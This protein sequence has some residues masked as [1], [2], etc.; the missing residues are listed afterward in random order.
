MFAKLL[1]FYTISLPVYIFNRFELICVLIYKNNER[2]TKK[3]LHSGDKAS[4]KIKA[5]NYVIGMPLDS[6]KNFSLEQ[7]TS[8]II[9]TVINHKVNGFNVIQKLYLFNTAVR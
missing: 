2:R 3:L 9:I 4:T 8:L 1:S 5:R 6:E 7:L